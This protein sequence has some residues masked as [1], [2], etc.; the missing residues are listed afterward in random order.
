MHGESVTLNRFAWI[1]IIIIDLI[2]AKKSKRF[3][4][5]ICFTS[6]QQHIL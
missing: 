4:K 5:Q 2:V 1:I 6:G 3:L